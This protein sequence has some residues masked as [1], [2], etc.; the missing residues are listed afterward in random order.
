MYCERE[1]PHDHPIINMNKS[2]ENLLISSHEVISSINSSSLGSGIPSKSGHDYLTED[3][4]DSESKHDSS[5]HGRSPSSSPQSSPKIFNRKDYWKNSGHGSSSGAKENDNFKNDDQSLEPANRSSDSTEVSRSSAAE[6][7]KEGRSDRGKK[8]SSWYNVLYP[9]YKS[10]SE[11]FKRI[12][13]DVPD[14]ERLVV[15]Y[16]CALQR[17]ILV[18]GRLY[19]SQNYVCFYANIFMWETLVSLR[20]KDVQSITKEK[21][22]LVIPNAI[23][24]CTNKDKFFLTTFGARDKTYLML[25][26]VW[27]NA[28]IGQPMSNSEMWQLVH[29]CYGEELGLTS[30]DEDYVP[31]ITAAEEEKLP[32]RVSTESFSE[33]D[34]LSDGIPTTSGAGVTTDIL[35]EA[36]AHNNNPIITLDSKP[37]VCLDPTDMSDTTESDAEK[38]ALLGDKNS[39]MCTS[40]HEG[41]RLVNVI[42]PIHVDQLFTLLFTN[43]KFFLDFHTARKTTNLIQ[44]AWAQDPQTN[45]KMRTVS[46][47]IS[48]TQAVGPRT[49]QVTEHQTMLP[50]S[51]PGHRYSIDVESINSG[52]PYADSFNV[53]SHFCIAAISENETSLAIFSQIHYKKHVWSVMKSIIEK[54]C[55][56]GLDEYFSSLT[57]ALS[58]ECEETAVGDGIKRKVRRRRRV[59]CPQTLPTPDIPSTL[60]ASVVEQP[61]TIKNIPQI[62]EDPPTLMNWVLLIAVLCLVVINGLLYYKLWGLEE[63]A[64]Y[65]VMD[66][67]VLRNTPKSEEDWVNLIQQQESLHNVEMRKWQRVLHTAAQL[68][69][70]TEDSL[71]ELQRSMHPTST[72]KVFSVLKPNLK[73]FYNEADDQRHNEDM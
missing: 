53:L 5:H 66:L 70:Q 18:H 58:V 56:A 27:Q 1:S 51:R 67:H 54:N 19:V 72:E 25:F 61:H 64:A 43:S 73:G 40:A 26:R 46:L 33:A 52:I 31:P 65:T 50:C 60:S 49:S 42:L 22:A 35:L 48:L 3:Y 69:K 62:R 55:W 10:R 4:H 63:A 12:F 20:W 29:A 30:D 9:T 13:K 28:L 59:A 32:S 47:T 68:L 34:V 23:S 41:R 44:P 2:V 16:S 17:E 45:Q 15:D 36:N 14:D 24:I 38:S 57:K 37:D 71:I 8:K 6:T 7:R 39:T 11:D 21:T